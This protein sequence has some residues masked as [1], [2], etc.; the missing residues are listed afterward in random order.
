[1]VL[2]ASYLAIAL[3]LQESADLMHSD[4]TSRLTSAVQAAHEGTGKYAY[5]V[6][7][8]GDGE[9]GDCVY[10]CD[11]S[12]YSAP[13]EIQNQG[14]KTT[15]NLD[16]ANAQKVAT[17]TSYEPVA[18]DA[19]NYA[20]MMEAGLYTKGPIP[21]IERFI[22]KGERDKMAPEDFAGKGKSFPINT[23][24]DIAAAVHSMGR[25]GDKN[26]GASTLKS[27]I[28]AIAK[29]KGWEK[30]LPKTWQGAETAEAESRQSSAAGTLKLTES[31]DWTEQEA[32]ALVE[33]AGAVE[34]E[35]KIL[36]PG[37]GSSAIYTKEVMQR[38]GPSTFKKGTQIFINHATKA[39]ESARPEGDWHKLVGALSGNAYWK[40]SAKHGDGLYGMAAFD[41][42]VAPSILTKAP[43]SGMSIR[44]N[45]TAAVEAGRTVT[46]NGKPVLGAFTG[47][48]SIDIVTRAGA[49]G[50]I[51]TESA[52]AA[53]T[54]EVDMTEAEVKRLIEAGNAPL[55]ARA[56]RGDALVEASRVL[57]P[58]HGMHDALKQEVIT[59]VIGD[60]LALPIKE[61]ELDTA[62]FGELVMAEA[63]R[64]ASVFS[65]AGGTIRVQGLGVGEP[66]SIDVKTREAQRAEAKE[67]EDESVRVFESLMGPGPA[68]AI[69]AKGRAA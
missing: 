19:D 68:A 17:R 63:K 6:D 32:L 22:S 1:M 9:S 48:E 3:D 57:S 5:Y 13:Y 62:K 47:C 10:G 16:T 64:V 52:R 61:G 33:S 18:D 44:A 30:Y 53:T 42:S 2:R 50:M 56:L 66:V 23:P 4:V 20:S 65:Q 58:L 27:R 8:N 49:G 40:E 31:I 7:H 12:R 37:E 14:G 60:G 51:L 34:R 45:G 36:A 39:E 21:L 26:V 24:G 54:Q 41:P 28:V 46:K 25:A 67:I 29:R 59:R 38:D 11:G 69:A 43:W 15:A 55:L 35:I